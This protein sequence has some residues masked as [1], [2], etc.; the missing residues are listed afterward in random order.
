MYA[1]TTTAVENDND[2]DGSRAKG[3]AVLC[4]EVANWR[5]KHK[6]VRLRFRLST[7]FACCV[8]APEVEV[9][10]G[11]WGGFAFTTGMLAGKS[12]AVYCACMWLALCGRTIL[13]KIR[14][15]VL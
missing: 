9:R 2:D 5:S 4:V 10:R 14:N 6:L 15:C 12:L 13:F 7:P 1:C 11:I 3:V 8:G